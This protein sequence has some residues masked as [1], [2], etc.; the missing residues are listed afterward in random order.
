LL[1]ENFH[2]KYFCYSY[3]VAKQELHAHFSLQHLYVS[4]PGYFFALGYPVRSINK[5]AKFGAIHETFLAYGK[6]GSS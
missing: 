5:W 1:F 2:N 4:M 3:C 6:V